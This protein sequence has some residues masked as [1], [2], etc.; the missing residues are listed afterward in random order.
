MP[1]KSSNSPSQ[2]R[3]RWP[4]YG[5]RDLVIKMGNLLAEFELNM[6]PCFSAPEGHRH[7]QI[8]TSR[9]GDPNE[10][11]THMIQRV[12]GILKEFEPKGTI[13]FRETPHHLHGVR[14]GNEENKVLVG[15][16]AFPP[17]REGDPL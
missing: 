6:A 11:T 16:V 4:E 10:A 7:F 9:C 3:N 1:S 8:K 12:E 13:R 15:S 17:Y 2:N 14:P 5:Q